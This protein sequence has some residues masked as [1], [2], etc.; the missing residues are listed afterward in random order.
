MSIEFILLDRKINDRKDSDFD[1]DDD[2]DINDH[3]KENQ[4]KRRADLAEAAKRRFS[5][6]NVNKST[7]L[8]NVNKKNL[9]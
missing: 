6:V 9:T 8:T 1:S 7:T 5:N 2:D 3:N 4:R